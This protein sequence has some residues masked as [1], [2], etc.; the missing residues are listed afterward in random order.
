[1]SKYYIAVA[2]VQEFLDYTW[3]EVKKTLGE[4]FDPAKPYAG[5]KTNH[6]NRWFSD[7]FVKDPLMAMFDVVYPQKEWYDKKVRD[8]FI[9]GLRYDPETKV[10]VFNWF[11]TT[12]LGLEPKDWHYKK[13]FTGED[14]FRL[15]FIHYDIQVLS[16][17]VEELPPM[18]VESLSLPKTGLDFL[19]E[20]R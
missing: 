19:S 17:E 11:G 2:D 1:M 14:H 3:K 8:Y 20:V 7:K 12:G 10:Y 16:T 13:Y 18:E 9:S 5:P 4:D 15:G 6:S